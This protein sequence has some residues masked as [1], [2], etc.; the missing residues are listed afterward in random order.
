MQWAPVNGKFRFEDSRI[1]FVG[2]PQKYGEETGSAVGQVMCDQSFSGGTISADVTFPELEPKSVCN[3]VFWYHPERRYFFSAGISRDPQ[4][5]YGIWHFDTKWNVHAAS[6]DGSNLQPGRKYH[7]QLQLRG[8]RAALSV[9]GVL[10]A[11]ATL[12]FSLPPSQVGLWFR[13]LHDITVEGFT[14]ASETPRVFVVMQLA[15]PFDEL[16]REVLKTVC[17]EFDLE[18][19]RADETYGPGLII[20]DI[21]KQIQ[22]AKFVIAEITPPN[23]NVYFEVGY[24]HAINKP[25]ILLAERSIERLPFDI[26]PFR[27]LFYEN[28]IA[29]KSRV[30]EGLRRH[31]RA[32]LTNPLF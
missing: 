11:V 1:V 20:A 31:I 9:D 28:T 18:A 14:V 24:A 12:P 26:S 6:G 5:L 29:G 17:K 13:S 15:S 21:V 32:V 10:V 8:S 16:H 19:I 30:E 2:G 23:P 7:L 22:E 25:T 4:S 27:T 3:I